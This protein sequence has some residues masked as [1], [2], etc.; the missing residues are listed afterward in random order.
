MGLQIAVVPAGMWGTALAVPA[1]QGGHTVRLWRR[2]PGWTKT[3]D[4]GHQALPGLRLPQNVVGCETVAEAVAEADL[5]ILA[6]ASGALR[7]HCQWIRPHLRRDVLLVSV[8]KGLDP[9]RHLRMSQVIAEELPE[10][11]GRI[12]ALSGPN[13]AQEVAAGLPTGTVVACPDRAVAEAV[14][15]ALMTSRFRVYTNPDLV[16]V[17]LAGALKNVMAIAA[18]ISDGL[19]MGDNARAALITRGL[20]EISRLGAALGASPFTF[21]GLA[22][23]GDLVLTCTSDTSRNRRLGLAVGR[24]ESAESFTARTGLTVEGLTTARAA[25]HWARSLGVEMPITEQ[26][27]TVLYEGRSPLEAMEQ[28]MNRER[29]RELWTA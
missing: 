15:D 24:G 20:A 13:F 6:P 26:V 25:Y 3:W 11:R 18:G 19:G 22:G 27:Y 7:A 9:E 28:L 12:A 10:H 14:Q 4:R 21:A 2:T 5:V 1:A 8:T 17:E 23:L 16:G 29:T